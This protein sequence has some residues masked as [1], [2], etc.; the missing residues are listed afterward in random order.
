M[1]P[2]RHHL[3]EAVT[4]AA[5]R[6]VLR[7]LALHRAQLGGEHLVRV[8][9]RDRVRVRVRVR[10]HRAQL[11]GEHLDTWGCRLAWQ[12]CRAGTQGC[13]AGHAGLQV[14]RPSSGSG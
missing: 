5:R 9:V 8:R 4:A 3:E 14:P 10:L 13:R 7:V 2:R 11:A 6:L 12:C 1:A